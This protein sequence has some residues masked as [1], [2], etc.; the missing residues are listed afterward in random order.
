MSIKTKL[1]LIQYAKYSREVLDDKVKKIT[2][3][4]KMQ[5]EDLEELTLIITVLNTQEYARSGL[6]K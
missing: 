3:K 5:Q 1:K 6:L 4:Y 2:E